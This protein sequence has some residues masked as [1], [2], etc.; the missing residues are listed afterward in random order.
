MAGETCTLLDIMLNFFLAYKEE[1]FRTFEMD[2][3]KISR[4]YLKG[5]FRQ[6]LL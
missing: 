3:K 2:F 4:R 5:R 6:D 1:G